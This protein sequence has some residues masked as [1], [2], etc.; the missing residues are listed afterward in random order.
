M[1]KE[2]FCYCLPGAATVANGFCPTTL[3]NT[4]KIVQ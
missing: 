1:L 3:Y 2:L 4:L